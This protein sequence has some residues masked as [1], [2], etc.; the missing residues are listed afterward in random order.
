[1]TL[2]AGGDAPGGLELHLG[3]AL[4]AA[5]CAGAGDLAG[6]VFEALLGLLRPVA[7]GVGGADQD[8]GEDALHAG[9][10]PLGLDRLLESLLGLVGLLPQ[11]G[12]VALDVFSRLVGLFAGIVT[13]L[14]GL[15]TRLLQRFVKGLFA[16]VEQFGGAG[17]DLLVE[18]DFLG[19]MLL[20]GHGDSSL[21]GI[22]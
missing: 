20:L 9:G 3:S 19:V 12:K 22:W 4:L 21:H 5:Q 10:H 13:G 15:F 2:G 18:S 6:L 14:G 1:V 7:E 16:F 11:F 8:A 17:G